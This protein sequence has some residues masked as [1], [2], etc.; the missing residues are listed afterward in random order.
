MKY[1]LSFLLLFVTVIGISQTELT[2]ATAMVNI[3]DTSLEIQE[4]L[5]LM[6]P[7]SVKNIT[8]K[9]LKFDQT[10]LSVNVVRANGKAVTFQQSQA[11]GLDIIDI[12]L[13]G[14]S[15][16]KIEVTYT[17]SVENE[18][19]Y[20]PMFFTDFPVTTSDNDFFKLDIQLKQEQDYIIHFPKVDKIET[21]NQ[22][23][24]KVMLNIPA[25]PSL[26]RMELPAATAATFRIS[27]FIDWMVAF[28]FV[29]IGFLIWRYRK[30][31]MYG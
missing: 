26:I 28:I 9:A 31:L 21:S 29:I 8:L 11:N 24:K 5:N 10:I 30:Q 3:K 14:E 15:I 2:N 27:N 22:G 25:L 19:F 20:I 4:Q 6:L 13:N 7:D 17:V 18:A 23:V 1:T 12:T 16:K